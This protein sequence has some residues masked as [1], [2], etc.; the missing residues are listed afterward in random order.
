MKKGGT[1]NQ[2]P[3]NIVNN[4][5]N[6]NRNV[7]NVPNENVIEV[8]ELCYPPCVESGMGGQTGSFI[9]VPMQENGKCIIECGKK[10][11]G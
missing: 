3:F 7:I 4:G 2:E 11:S 8:H 5:F 6:P 9:N 10:N 1:I